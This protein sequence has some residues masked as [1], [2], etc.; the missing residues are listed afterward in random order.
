MGEALFIV[1]F[2]YLPVSKSTI[3]QVITSPTKIRMSSA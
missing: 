3:N 1:E 2:M